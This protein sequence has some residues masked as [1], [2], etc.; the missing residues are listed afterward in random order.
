MLRTS[1]ETFAV[2]MDGQTH[3]IISLR[4]ESLAR[5]GDWTK[6]HSFCYSNLDLFCSSLHCFMCPIEPGLM[7]EG[8]QSLVKWVFQG[9][10]QHQ[11]NQTEQAS[12]ARVDKCVRSLRL[13]IK[14]SSGFEWV[15]FSRLCLESKS[16][17]TLSET[18]NEILSVKIALQQVF[19][20]NV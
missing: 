3:D 5:T 4:L 17:G 19:V 8:Q 11:W 2:L 7:R 18:W 14:S 1:A 20:H 13:S 12:E 10:P 16:S 6:V 9:S 15:L